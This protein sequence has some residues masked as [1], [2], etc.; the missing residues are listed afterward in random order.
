MSKLNQ[1]IE[2]IEKLRKI[3]IKNVNAI[4]LYHELEGLKRGAKL[5]KEEIIDMIE[6]LF[7]EHQDN[8]H[9]ILEKLIKYIKGDKA[10]A[11]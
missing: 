10:N 6:R 4:T 3:N 5:Q 1:E 11:K 2:R 7:K 9:K 8:Y